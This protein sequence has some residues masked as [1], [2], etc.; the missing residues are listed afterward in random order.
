MSN[1]FGG[2]TTPPAPGGLRRQNATFGGAATDPAPKPGGIFGN[3]QGQPTATAA[4]Q[5]LFGGASTAAP[6]SSQPTG[7][8]TGGIFGGGGA[9]GGGQGPTPST[10]PAPTPLFG[11]PAPS[12]LGSRSANPTSGLG[13][14]TGGPA[15]STPAPAG[16]LSFP[17]RPQLGGGQSGI[18]GNPPAS[19]P[20]TNPPT[21]LFNQNPPQTSNP[22]NP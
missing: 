21:S 14:T 8:A 13:L 12:L 16:A 4:S 15:S 11:Q 1:L 19:Q 18:F 3:P 10:P 20:G 6:G 9:L 17:A 7:A 5:P 2:S 22:L